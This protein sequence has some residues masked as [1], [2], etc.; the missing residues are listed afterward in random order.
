MKRFTNIFSLTLLLLPLR[1]YA[2]VCGVIPD[3][4][5]VAVSALGVINIILLLT[6]IAS[7]GS[8]LYTT[9]FT[10]DNDG[11][12]KKYFWWLLGALAL[13]IA[14][15]VLVGIYAA[16]SATPCDFPPK[17]IQYRGI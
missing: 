4:L 13:T 14:V 8:Y 15:N 7:G 11:W 2:N 3:S 16:E 9:L 1:T 10:D 12:G 5:E 6:V 17:H